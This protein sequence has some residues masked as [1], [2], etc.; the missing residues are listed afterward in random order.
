MKGRLLYQVLKDLALQYKETNDPK[1]FL[2]ILEK[3]T[4]LQFYLVRKIRKSHPHLRGVEFDDFI[5]TSVLG[6]HRA[7]QTV[8]E[9]EAASRVV[10]R[11]EAYVKNEILKLYKKRSI[12]RSPFY[13]YLCGTDDLDKRVEKDLELDDIRRRFSC[14]IK[15]KV[16]SLEDFDIL[17]LRFVDQKPFRVISKVIGK[18]ESTV[19]F[20]IKSLINKV[21]FEF[22]RRG[23][24]EEYLD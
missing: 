6:I 24:D 17:V 16:I 12:K 3:T 10:S 21:R 22:R 1:L 9:G 13:E 2:A 5:Q 8:K 14:L 15:D 11:M 20:R 19:Y 4:K 18:P 23:W 7:L